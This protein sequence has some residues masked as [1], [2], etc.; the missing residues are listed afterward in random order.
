MA[1]NKPSKEKKNPTDKSK[2]QT[3]KSLSLDD[4]DNIDDI[5]ETVLDILSTFA[6]KN[7]DNIIVEDGYRI[8]GTGTS[9]ARLC[10][11]IIR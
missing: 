8:V 6:D 10:K 1:K 5:D 3:P 2:K 4:L 11:T 7:Y 9:N